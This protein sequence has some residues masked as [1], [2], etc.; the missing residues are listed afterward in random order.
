MEISLGYHGKE[1]ESE[2]LKRF[3]ARSKTEAKKVKPYISLALLALLIGTTACSAP[4]ES[5]PTVIIVSPPSGSEFREGEQVAVQ[6]TSEDAVGVVRV[7]LVADD[8]VVHTDAVNPAQRQVT[9]TQTWQATPGPH[10]IMVRAY[11]A[12]GDVS[13]PIAVS[14]TVVQAATPTATLPP[15]TLTPAPSPTATITACVD[16]AVFVADVTIP[17]GTSLAAGKSFEKTWRVRNA[18]CPWGAGYDLVFVSGEAMTATQVVP[19]PAT[20]EGETADLS[21]ALTAPTVPGTHSGTWRLRNPS[22]TLFG[23]IVFVKITVPGAA[24]PT[25]PPA[26]TQCSGTPNISSFTASERII[27]V[28]GKTTLSWGA[29]TNADHVEIDQGIG[30]I[31]TPGSIDVAPTS[32]TLYTLTA[33]CGSNTATAQVQIVLPFAVLGLVTNADTSDYIGAC[34]KTVTFSG[35]ITVNDAGTVTYKWESSDG[36]NDSP[37]LNLTFDGAGS[38]TVNHTWTLG[39]SGKTYADYWEHLHTLSPTGVI[40]NNATFTLRC[41]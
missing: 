6:S 1:S 12:A 23:T 38:T 29:V 26:A 36:S 8:V 35:T 15:P 18:G 21:V 25:N 10:I 5:K 17:D 2:R 37:I 30:E 4:K 16:S 7:E 14:M 39:A 41:N 24:Q 11:N 19:I 9:M 33:F 20:P 32:T 3:G 34:P 28:F 13:N 31:A 22:G 27:P 40:S